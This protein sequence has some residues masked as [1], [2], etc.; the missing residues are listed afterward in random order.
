MA[1]CQGTRPLW[2]VPAVTAMR[3]ATL[4]SAFEQAS[5]HADSTCSISILFQAMTGGRIFI[6][7][8]VQCRDHNSCVMMKPSMA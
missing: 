4:T 8:L 7:I 6:P 1:L 3:C 2:E 5:T